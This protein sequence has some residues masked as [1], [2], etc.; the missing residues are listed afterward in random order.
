M[1]LVIDIGNTQIKTAVFEENILIF[2]DQFESEQLFTGVL[3]IA[4]QYN[5]NMLSC[6]MLHI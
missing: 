2:K 4:E 1:N 6:R 5:I 3:S